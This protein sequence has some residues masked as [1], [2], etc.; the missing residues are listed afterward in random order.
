M[1]LSVNDRNG[2]GES[3]KSSRSLAHQQLK[4]FDKTNYHHHR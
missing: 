4:I 1:P 2:I 3:L